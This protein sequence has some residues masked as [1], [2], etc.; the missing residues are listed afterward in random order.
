[1]RLTLGQCTHGEKKN[2]TINTMKNELTLESQLTEG[3]SDLEA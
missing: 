1:M 2:S 3:R